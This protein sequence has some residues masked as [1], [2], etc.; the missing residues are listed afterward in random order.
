MS[1]PRGR[2][3]HANTNKLL[4]TGVHAHTTNT[5]LPFQLHQSALISDKQVWPVLIF[6]FMSLNGEL[7]QM[8]CA[9][10]EA[11]PSIGSG[12]LLF[13]RVTSKRYSHF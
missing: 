7:S 2:N 6:P 12:S 8:F 4:Y 1:S 3:P 9:P 13:R 11:L 5:F 10:V